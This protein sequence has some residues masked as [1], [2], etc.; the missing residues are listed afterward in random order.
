MVQS[1][2]NPRYFFLWSDTE[3]RSS[4]SSAI[5]LRIGYPTPRCE[6]F[7]DGSSHVLNQPNARREGP[8][9][10]DLFCALAA[11]AVVVAAAAAAAA[12]VAAVYGPHQQIVNL[13]ISWTCLDPTESDRARQPVSR[14]QLTRSFD[15]RNP[16]PSR[17]GLTRSAVLSIKILH[18]PKKE[19]PFL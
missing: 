18:I 17:R 10:S 12:A 4:A 3:E 19:K 15:D 6:L 5:R 11:S 13:L 16:K 9:H 7:V 1:K 14:L 8:S 2:Q